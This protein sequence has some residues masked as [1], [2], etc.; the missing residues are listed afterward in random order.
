MTEKDIQ[1]LLDKIEYL[2]QE[3]SKLKEQLF[4]FKATGK[5]VIVPEP[6][7]PIFDNAEEIVASYFQN[8]KA[9]PSEGS[10][11]INNERYVLMR[12]SSLSVD[13]LNKI[14]NLYADKGEKE[15]LLI[16]RKFLFDIAH[17]IG[18]EDAANF[19]EK[20]DVK[21]SISKLSAG[22]I[23]FAYSGWAK[24]E[25]SEESNP[26]PNDN[27]FLKYNHPYSFEAETWITK[28]IQSSEP[29]CIMNAGYSSGWCEQSFGIPL[30]A[31]EISCRAKGDANCTFVM[32]PPSKI[33]NFLPEI[34]DTNSTQK[35]E[36]PL[37]F[38]RKKAEDKIIQSLKEKDILLKEVHHRVKNNLQIVSSFLNLQSHYLSDN[39]SKEAFDKTINR[40]RAIAL[41]HEKLYQSKN[42][43]QIDIKT[44]IESIIQLL[45]EAFNHQI[46]IITNIEVK[47]ST[48]FN[49]DLAIP[50]GLII[51]EMVSNSI[52]YAK[53]HSNQIEIK[54]SFIEKET[55]FELNIEDNGT[56]LQDNASIFDKKTLGMEIILSLVEQLNGELITD[57]KKGAKFSV[58]IKK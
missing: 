58:L 48:F 54:V 1:L 53:N 52:K 20:M 23:H 24:V 27:F 37:F 28:G 55:Q 10:I 8:I 36:I 40:V 47:Q 5:T 56:T 3:N 17:V 14:K 44:Y 22:P 21:D 42:F 39:E 7:Q 4:P 38:E 51:N 41:V 33:K 9:N 2:E 29:V 57:F 46:N 50:C 6:I 49:I 18:I 31:V 13:F 35:F 45:D 43:E 19:H 30:T 25:I 34:S 15:A 11:E 16:G 12:A 32:A 26:E